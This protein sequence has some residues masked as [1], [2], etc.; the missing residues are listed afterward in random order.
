MHDQRRAH[1][2]RLAQIGR[3]GGVVDDQGDAVL[4]GN[5]RQR[6]DIGDIATGVGDGLAEDR[7]GV[8]VDG[9]LDGGQIVGIDK[10]RR[11]A[12]AF[13]DLREL[14]DRAAI[15]PGRGDDVQSWPHQRI[16]RHDLRRV[17]RRGADSPHATL[18]RRQTL[19]QGGDGRVGQARIDIA[20]FLQVEQSRGMVGIA[21]DIGGGLVDRNLAGAGGRIGARARVDLKR[22]E[23]KAGHG[24]LPRGYGRDAMPKASVSQRANGGLRAGPGEDV[25]LTL[26]LA[27]QMS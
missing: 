14:G 1:L 27:E 23:A 7:A 12:K 16:E 2:D 6:R 10:G 17:S 11:P 22:V 19:A 26:P 9:G 21:K 24:V 18:Q 4:V 3:G 25:F 5:R 13:E 20:D 8:L 15:E